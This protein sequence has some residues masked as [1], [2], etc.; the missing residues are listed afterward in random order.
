MAGLERDRNGVFFENICQAGNT[1]KSSLFRLSKG[2]HSGKR[3]FSPQEKN[4]TTA[5]SG[6]IFTELEPELS[7]V[8]II[9]TFASEGRKMIDKVIKEKSQ[10]KN[11]E[12]AH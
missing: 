2:T 8:P 9:N 11:H 1:K 4:K 6:F 3:T 10:L 12:K 5:L 7:H